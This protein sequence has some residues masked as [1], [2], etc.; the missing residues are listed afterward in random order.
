M[1]WM[2]QEAFSFNQN[3][4]NWDTSSVIDMTGMFD[5][6]SSFN[7]DLSVWCVSNITIAPLNFSAFTLMPQS[8][9][10]IWGSCP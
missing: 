8:Y 6:A 2:F 7:Q 4:S 9:N 5:D 3:I 10:P 1:K